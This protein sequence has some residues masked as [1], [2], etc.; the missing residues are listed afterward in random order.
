MT[1]PRLTPVQRDVLE[2]LRDGWWL[3][4]SPSV[5][6]LIKDGEAPRH[7]A[8]VTVDALTRRGLIG[9]GWDARRLA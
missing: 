5:W 7:V 9:D 8:D 3:V 2:R 6:R 4:W 1:K